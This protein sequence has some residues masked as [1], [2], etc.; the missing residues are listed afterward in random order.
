MP[1]ERHWKVFKMDAVDDSLSLIRK[2]VTSEPDPT[3]IAQDIRTLSSDF[4]KFMTRKS[5]ISTIEPFCLSIG[6][7]AAENRLPLGYFP[8]WLSP[9]RVITSA[10]QTQEIGCTNGC[11]FS[12]GGV[13]R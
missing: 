8:V 2:K 9:C 10:S 5:D 11:K 4:K 13:D 3:R 7:I 12:G 1:N 6:L